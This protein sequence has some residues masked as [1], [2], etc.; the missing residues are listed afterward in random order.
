LQGG[1]ID[2]M[3]I[4]GSMMVVTYGDGSIQSFDISSGTPVSN[5]DEQNSTAYTGMQGATYPNSVE[6]TQDG[7]FALFGDTSTAAIVEV[8]DV[9]SGKLST[10]VPYGI[11]AS[12]NS[13]NILLSPDETMLYV[14]NTQGDTVGAAFFDKTT[15]QLKP[16][17]ISGKLRGY[18]FAWSYL[19]QLQLGS[20]TGTGRVIYVA[21][22]GGPAS[23]STIAVNVS[24]GTC[25]LVELSGSP[26]ADVNSP[27]LLS[28]G[29][30]PP[31]SF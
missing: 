10:T 20:N 30:Y 28:I 1:F 11:T 7:H 17:C 13:S 14:S 29:V 12:I 8:S 24:G 23:I 21:E 4:H 27:G 5:G 31:R 2:A 16:G 26:V 22:F 15:G 3:T 9:S 6:I 18:S 19:S 25:S